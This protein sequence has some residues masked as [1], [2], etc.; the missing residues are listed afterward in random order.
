MAG[1]PTLAEAGVTDPK[2]RQDWLHIA[3]FQSTL[4]DRGNLL[5]LERLLT[6]RFGKDCYAILLEQSATGRLVCVHL[7]VTPEQAIAEA[8]SEVL[9][10]G[11]DVGRLSQ[12]TYW[13][14]AKVACQEFWRVAHMAYR[15]DLADGAEL[16]TRV[17]L[18]DE[19]PEEVFALIYRD[20][21]D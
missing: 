3:T 13:E 20:I 16:S 6:D 7:L 19:M 9:E 21:A 11:D 15:S 18:S 8:L 4:V 2:E 17:T 14:V 12:E 10:T 1:F 5:F